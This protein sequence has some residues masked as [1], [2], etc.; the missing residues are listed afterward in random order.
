MSGDVG[1]LIGRLKKY[2]L[3]DLVGGIE[4]QELCNTLQ[5]DEAFTREQKITLGEIAVYFADRLKTGADEKDAQVVDSF[6]EKL[7]SLFIGTASTRPVTPSEPANGEET[8][9]EVL[10]SFTQEA[11]DHLENIEEK[12][13]KLEG[14]SDP[15]LVNNIF[16][17]MHTIKGVS[18]FIGLDKIKQLSHSLELALDGV[19]EGAVSVTT[20]VIDVL[21]EGTGLLNRMIKELDEKAKDLRGTKVKAITLASSV[22][23]ESVMSALKLITEHPGKNTVGLPIT[24]PDRDYLDAQR[25]DTFIANS[26]NLLMAAE[27]KLKAFETDTENQELIVEA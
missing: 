21:L 19:R 6:V 1:A 7:E 13:L 3:G 20:D 23:I 22:N 5:N 16:R 10:F 18:S 12:I 2:L 14:G 15:E 8:D 4:I 17:S 25:K 11:L 24:P 9:H 27:S 26:R